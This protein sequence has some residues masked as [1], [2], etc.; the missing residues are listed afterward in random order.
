[1]KLAT[2]LHLLPRLMSGNVPLFLFLHG[3]DRINFNFTFSTSCL[4][5]SK[6]RRKNIQFSFSTL[7]S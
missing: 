7:F 1:M 3:V 5:Q 2:H 4:E 6:L